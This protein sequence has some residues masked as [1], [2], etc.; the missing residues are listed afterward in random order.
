MPT[1]KRTWERIGSQ[2][3]DCVIES[4]EHTGVLCPQYLINYDEINPDQKSP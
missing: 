2:V 3:L 4:E 1:M